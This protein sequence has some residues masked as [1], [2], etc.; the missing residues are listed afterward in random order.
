MWR[1][2]WR[3]KKNLTDLFP[4]DEFV[5]DAVREERVH[6]ME[7]PRGGRSYR[8]RY[9]TTICG[10]VARINYFPSPENTR[11][12]V[13]LGLYMVEFADESR[14][15]AV[16]VNWRP[17]G[18]RH[19]SLDVVNVKRIPD[20]Q[21]RA[22]PSAT[23]QTRLSRPEQPWFR[24]A[25]E[26]AYAA[27]CCITGCGVGAVLEAAHIAPHNPTRREKVTNGLLLRA[28][29]H[30]LFDTGHLAVDPV[31]RKVHFSPDVLSWP[32]YRRLHKRAKL[33]RPQRGH[34]CA[35]PS[36]SAFRRRWSAFQSFLTSR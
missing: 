10:K 9:K 4:D 24:R 31:T 21:D 34:D 33:R 28:D 7:G 13:D 15:S 3:S 22:T 8:A 16:R 20:P 32:E 1:F 6:V 30:A 36:P 35:M 14:T 17:R 19:P 12:D 18:A 26:L 11:F 2:E 23:A 5:H 27:R 29:L 25:L